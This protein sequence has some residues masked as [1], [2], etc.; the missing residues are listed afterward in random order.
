M[1]RVD[2][3]MQTREAALDLMHRLKPIMCRLKPKTGP[4]NVSTITFPNIS[5][6]G[7][8]P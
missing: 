2:M 6:I 1:M 7:E 8:T 5:D 4:S 3:M